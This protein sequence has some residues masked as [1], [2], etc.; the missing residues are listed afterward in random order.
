MTS[1][2]DKKE[3]ENKVEKEELDDIIVEDINGDDGTDAQTVSGEGAVKRLRERLKKCE[4]DKKEYLDGW[5]RAKADL[6]NARKE[7]EKKMNEFRKFSN[8]MLLEDIM[9][10]M[11]SFDRAFAGES[12]EKVDKVWRDGIIFLYNQLLAT[13]KSYGVEMVESTGKKFFT[14][15]HEAV[16]EV[17]VED[18][19]QDGIVIEEL[20]KGYKIHNKIIRPAQVRVGVKK[21]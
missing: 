10:T 9:Q 19:K 15:E 8:A 12:W 16:G 7:D 20:R 13:L 6:I 11:D 5:Q 1:K 2:K 14:A 4:Q 3:P 17:D 18:E 21:F